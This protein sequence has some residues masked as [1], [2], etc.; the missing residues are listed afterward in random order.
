MPLERP[1]YK[2]ILQQLFSQVFFL[3]FLD[4]CTPESKLLSVDNCSEH[5]SKKVQERPRTKIKQKLWVVQVDPLQGTI[6]AECRV[7]GSPVHSIFS[8]TSSP[9]KGSVFP[10]AGQFKRTSPFLHSNQ[11]ANTFF[12]SEIPS[13]CSGKAGMELSTWFMLP[14][15]HGELCVHRSTSPLLAH[16]PKSVQVVTCT[17]T[18]SYQDNFITGLE[19]LA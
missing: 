6:R 16:K 10:V 13:T 3:C 14:V 2:T 17:G 19:G 18:K 9:R 5:I 12:L 11:V 8:R 7:M 15:L 4:S 1:G